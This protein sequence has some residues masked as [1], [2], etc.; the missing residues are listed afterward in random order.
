MTNFGGVSGAQLR[1]FI[2]RIERLEEEKSNI[3]QDI[4]EVYAEAKSEGFD[5]KIMRQ[6]LKIRKMDTDERAEQEE[7]LT[8]YM[9][10]LGMMRSFGQVDSST[11]SA[12]EMDSN[13]KASQ[14][15]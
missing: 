8:I 7:I 13:D 14:A 9:H 6:I 5:A 15:A 4:R 12:L 1:Q 2:E 10:A 3:A 11:E